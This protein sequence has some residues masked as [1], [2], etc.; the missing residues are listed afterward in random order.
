MRIIT[1]TAGAAVAVLL[2][3]CSSRRPDSVNM[4]SVITYG[5]QCAG[6]GA[7]V[8]AGSVTAE[9]VE[10]LRLQSSTA[11]VKEFSLVAEVEKRPG[12]PDAWTFNGIVPGPEIRVQQGDHVHVTLINHLPAATTIHWHGIDVPNAADGVAGVTQDAVKPGHSYTYDFLV[13]EP[14]TYWYHS[15]QDTSN[16][17]PRGLFGPL[18]VEPKNAPYYDRDYTLVYHDAVPP[19]RGFFPTIARILGAVDRRSVAVNGTPGDLRLSAN[20][21]ELVR[22]RLIN[23]TAG[24]TRA[25][26]APLHI[27][28]LGAPYR[29]VALDGHDLNGPQLI[30]PEVLPLGAGQRYDIELRMPAAGV[31]RLVDVGLEETVTLGSGIVRIPDLSKLSVF[32]LTRYG[33]PRAQ[34]PAPAGFDAD[35]T[36][37]LGSRPGFHFG[38]FGLVHTIDGKD[39]PGT[40]MILVRPGQLV[41]LHFTNRGRTEEFHTMHL[42]GHVFTVLARNGVPLSGSPVRLDTLLVAPKETWDVAFRA[43]NPGLWMLHC[44][45][46]LHA[47]TGMDM[48][49]SYPGIVTPYSVGRVSGNVP[50]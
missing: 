7:G 31:V 24:E 33:V 38:K 48:M 3:G 49:V 29:V 32:D 11:S 42:H 14:G 1:I 6:G 36:V 20:A 23:A 43:D 50:E 16:Q 44:H 10:N 22:L 17:I 35:Y 40:P 9:S 25:D 46:L 2:A 47:A 8:A 21:G 39:F 26:A 4:S 28:A 5:L 12:L 45:V 19:A 30:G 27:V 15:H 41:K 37:D 18:V 34:A 13:P